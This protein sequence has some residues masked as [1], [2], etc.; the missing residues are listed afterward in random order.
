MHL[1]ME[2]QSLVAGV[3]VLKKNHECEV[4]CCVSEFISGLECHNLDGEDEDESEWLNDLPHHR[5]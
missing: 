1:Y 3:S 2:D 4:D 5:V